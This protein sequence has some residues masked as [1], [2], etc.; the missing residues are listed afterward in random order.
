MTLGQLVELEVTAEDNDVGDTVTLT[1]NLTR[2]EGNDTVDITEEA[3]FTDGT[4]QWTPLTA[5][6]VNLT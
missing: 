1:F 3:S 6:P 2:Q 4:F 5:H